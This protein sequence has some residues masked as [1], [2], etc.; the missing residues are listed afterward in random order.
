MKGAAVAAITAGLLVTGSDAIQLVK[1]DTPAVV[2]I[3]IQRNSINS[4]VKRDRLRRRANKTV[5]QTL[6]NYEVRRFFIYTEITT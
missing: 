3:G 1:R 6:D 4:P 2:A 5:T